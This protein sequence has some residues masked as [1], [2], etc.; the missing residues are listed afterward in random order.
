MLGPP[1]PSPIYTYQYDLFSIPKQI[2]LHIL[3]SYSISKLCGFIEWA[4]VI[5]DLTAKIHTQENT[6]YTG[7]LMSGESH[8]GFFF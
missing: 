5:I 2:Y 6:Y 1:T 4:S 7:V 8:L 3:V